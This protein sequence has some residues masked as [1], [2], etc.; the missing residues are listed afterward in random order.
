MATRWTKQDIEKLAGKGIKVYDPS[1]GD[2]K[3]NMVIDVPGKQIQAPQPAAFALGRLK[4]GEMNKTEALYAKYLETLKFLG[5][6]LWYRFEPLN[7]K[8]APK[9][10]YQVDFLVMMKN[11]SIECH[12]V[13]GYWQ[14]D[15]LVK[16]KTAAQI[17]PFRFRAV[18]L[19]GGE[20]E[21]RDF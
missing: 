3:K 6:V 20:W 10:Y 18:R 4:D 17:F 1:L 21:Y 16:I 12:E 5:E 11:G 15:A 7:L 14:D 19:V 8:L 9:C 2:P 13:K